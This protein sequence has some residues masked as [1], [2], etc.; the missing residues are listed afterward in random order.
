MTHKRNNGY[1]L[2]LIILMIT[3]VMT[4]IAA[5]LRIVTQSYI[6]SREEYFYKLAQEAGEAGAAYANACLDKNSRVQTW[7]SAAGGVGPLTPTSDC[8]GAANAFASNGYVLV[9]DNIRTSFEVGN[10]DASEDYSA[11]VPSNGRTE[12][13]DGSGNVVRTFKA[14]V[15]KSI[16]W[17]ADLKATRS[18]SGTNRTCAI[19]SNN[20]WCWGSN[21][22]GQLGNGQSIGTG[23]DINAPASVDSNIPVRVVK[24]P[25]ALG[26]QTIKD[27]FTA[28]HHSCALTAVGKVYCWGYNKNG[29][30]G[31]GVSGSGAHSNV[32]VEVKGD[33]QGKVVTAIG[34]SGDSSCAIAGGKIY[35]WGDGYRG[36]IGDG[37]R[38]SYSTPRLVRAGVTNGLPTSYTATKLATSGTRSYNMCAIA[39]GN[40]YCWGDNNVG[41]I[42]NGTVATL[43]AAG[44][45]TP[46]TQP[47]RVSGLSDVTDI[48]QDG[49][50]IYGDHKD[51]YTHVCAISSGKVYCWGHGVFGQLGSLPREDVVSTPRQ[52]NMP[53]AI[54]GETVLRVEVGIA[55]S[56]ML[57]S[58]KKVYCWGY[59]Q[60]G[61][62]GVGTSPSVSRSNTPLPVVVGPRGIPSGE[63]VMD[64]SAGANR[65][66][67]VVSNGR[68]Y[69]W[70]YNNTGQIGDGTY[71]NRFYPTESLFLR[72]A[73]NRFIF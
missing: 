19:L 42:G 71:I 13:V 26:N 61:Q 55:H 8:T 39:N 59:N 1:S 66:C 9:T 65:G 72:P 29:Q 53:A 73:Q 46:V 21:R 2:V 41:Q 5:T 23:T 43:S 24:E 49:F 62:L 31:N 37:T 25:G 50:N 17:A 45:Y 28:Q 40:A 22:Y 20:I 48:S 64:I 60:V 57:T 18:A 35:C 52:I 34:G 3:F 58:S 10:L 36:V 51:R 30:L 67:A 70:G 6:Y 32:P 27:F 33:L 15:K 68:S 11:Q 4:V 44:S 56:C 14:S 47:T 69:C 7:G 12:L 16:T 54:S 38:N 63:T